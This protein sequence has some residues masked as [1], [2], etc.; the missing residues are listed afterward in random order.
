[1]Q[2]RKVLNRANRALAAV[3]A[4]CILIG[5]ALAETTGQW[6]CAKCGTEVSSPFCPTCGGTK[7]TV[8]LKEGEWICICGH[9][10]RNKFCGKCGTSR[11]DAE[12]RRTQEPA[13][14]PEP[15]PEPKP[16]P[17]SA[18]RPA[19]PDGY[20]EIKNA[21]IGSHVYYGS[22][23]Q[24]AR[25][26]DDTK[27]EWIVLTRDRTSCTLISRYALDCKPY[28][29]GKASA[30][31]ETCSLRKWLNGDFCNSAFSREEQAYLKTVTVSADKNPRYNT[32]VGNPTQDKVYLLSLTEATTLIG[33]KEE[34]QCKPTAYAE[35]AGASSAVNGY[36]WWRLRTPGADSNRAALVF[37]DG[38]VSHQGGDRVNTNAGGIRPVIVI[39]IQ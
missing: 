5:S 18:P 24:T 36:C 10:N 17:S 20:Q 7:E 26:N 39:K 8:G 31:W 25:G 22:Y 1:M 37:L 30:T 2:T 6:T 4:I 38:S 33:S 11:E 35:K 14:A 32:A 13:H 34:R 19:Y 21:G 23:P 28:N 9:V 3:L 16:E 29:Q 15:E 27:I 12:K